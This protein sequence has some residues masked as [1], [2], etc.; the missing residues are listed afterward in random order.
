MRNL[1]GA[2]T[3]A[4]L[5]AGCTAYT[6]FDPLDTTGALLTTEGAVTVKATFVPGGYTTPTPPPNYRT[7]AVVPR[8]TKERIDHLKLRF[9]VLEGETETPVED[10]NGAALVKSVTAAEAEAGLTIPRLTIGRS[11][12]VKATAYK[13]SEATESTAISAEVAVDFKLD[14]LKPVTEV[15]IRLIDVPFD[16]EATFPGFEITPSGEFGHE[17]SIVIDAPQYDN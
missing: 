13:T 12:R 16:G 7:A 17:G 5:L 6:P 8:M 10:A 4:T 1:I 9:F 15:G 3:A 11:Y 2:M 14:K